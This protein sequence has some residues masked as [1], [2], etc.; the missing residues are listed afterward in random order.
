M[1]ILSACLLVAYGIVKPRQKKNPNKAG[2]D[3]D[4]F[5]F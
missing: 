1:I 3:Q 4:L 2:T 5:L